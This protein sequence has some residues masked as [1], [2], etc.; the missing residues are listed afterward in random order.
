MGARA[1]ARLVAATL[2][3]V[4][5]V[6]AG[7]SAPPGAPLGSTGSATTEPPESTTPR[8]TIAGPYKPATDKG[9][10][11]NVPVPVLPEAA[12]EFSKEGL[13]AFAEYWFSTLGY[14]YETGDSGP[15]MAV[16]E[17]DCETCAYV[18]EPLAKT[19]AE[20]G[21]VVGGQM[22]VVQT[23]CY[24]TPLSDGDYQA[25]VEALQIRVVY[26]NGD[27]T[28][29]TRHEQNTAHTSIVNAH[30]ADGQWTASTSEPLKRN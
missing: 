15:M 7:C 5:L 23:V 26:Y 27:G 17:P 13:E 12:K 25:Q 2:L 20:G 4:V 11:E 21:W 24:F 16:T 1:F 30:W 6:L 28:V 14:V 8:P 19:Y 10:A 29:R 3:A 22:E 18:N 9:P